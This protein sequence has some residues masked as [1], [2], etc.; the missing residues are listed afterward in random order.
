MDSGVRDMIEETVSGS[1]RRGKKVEIWLLVAVSIL[2]LL[3]FM[4]TLSTG[5]EEAP[6]DL[7]GGRASVS[8]TE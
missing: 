3:G 5:D 8:V 6:T 2:G 4:A 7:G 1:A